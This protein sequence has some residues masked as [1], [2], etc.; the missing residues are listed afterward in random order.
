M[1]TDNGGVL[2]NTPVSNYISNTE[3]IHTVIEV[4]EEGGAKVKTNY[5]LYGDGR[6]EILRHYHDLKED[7]KR[8]FFITNMEWK[9]PDVFELS[10]S[11][12]KENPYRVMATMDYEKI[13]S[14]NAGSKLFFETRLYPIFDEEIPEYEKRMRDYYFTYPYQVMDTTV[15]KFPPG[16]SLETMPKNK[17]V[18]FPFAQYTCN[19]SWD[20]AT[21]TLT[22][23]ALLQIKD[24]VIMAADY[25][26]LVDF[27]KQVMAD[28][29]EKIVMKKQ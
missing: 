12:Y 16:F 7:E 15:Y 9:H 23:V 22:S 6:D 5:S 27:R 18:Q 19:Y 29:N 17:L 1:I 21:H 14:F 28:V 25:T 2:V 26:K 20:A 13:Y 11:K 4:N 24:R 8:K 3:S 10:N